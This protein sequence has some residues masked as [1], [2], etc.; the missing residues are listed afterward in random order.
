MDID[1]V[2]AAVGNLLTPDPLQKNI[3]RE[4]VKTL[5]TLSIS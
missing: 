3:E 1:E 2:S 4:T 5:V